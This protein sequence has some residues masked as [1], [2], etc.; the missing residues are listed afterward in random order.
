MYDIDKNEAKRLFLKYEGSH[1]YMERAGEYNLY[2]AFNVSKEQELIWIKEYEQQI[3]DILKNSNDVA[4]ADSYYSILCRVISQYKDVESLK[5]LLKTVS[6]AYRKFDSFTKLRFAEGLFSIVE[7]FNNY[8]SREIQ[9]LLDAK[10]LSVEIL[11]YVI[12]NP[13]A[14]DPYYKNVDYLSDILTKEEIINRA[15]RKIRSWEKLKI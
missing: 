10:K 9:V 11:K 8:E 12:S 5:A 13:V 14:I 15:S 6:Q 4:S 2:K 3:S 7:S 1:F